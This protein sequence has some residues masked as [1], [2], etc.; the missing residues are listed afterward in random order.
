MTVPRD[1]DAARVRAR[2]ARDKLMG[3]VGTLQQR[4]KPANLA[5]EAVENAKQSV[6]S[7][8]REGTEAVRT[9]P[10]LAAAVTSG[11]GLVFARGWIVD[12]FRKGKHETAGLP[13]GSATQNSNAEG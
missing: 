5:Q 3:T 2:A 11:I 4:L 10:W 1:P 12:I 13:K 6:T 8:A 9:R 7:I